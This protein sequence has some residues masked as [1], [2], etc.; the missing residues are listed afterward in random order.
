[1]TKNKINVEAFDELLKDCKDPAEVEAVFKQPKK[2]IVGAPWP[3]SSPVSEARRIVEANPEGQSDHRNGT[4]S[5][6][7]LTD[8]GEVAIDV[9]RDREGSFEPQLVKEGQRRLPAFDD[10]VLSMYGRGMTVREIQRHLQDL[11]LTS[12]AI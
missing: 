4:S 5:N 6:A 2:A 8:S 1:M 11:A 3:A 9:P 12:R 7:L 10:K